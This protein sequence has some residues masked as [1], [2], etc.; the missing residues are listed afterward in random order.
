MSKAKIVLVA[1][2]WISSFISATR[3]LIRKKDTTSDRLIGCS[4]VLF[5][6]FLAL[7]ILGLLAN[8]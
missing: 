6:F 5:V 1:G 2:A 4:T 3:M 8:N 7:M